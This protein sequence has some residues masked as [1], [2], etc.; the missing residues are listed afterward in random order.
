[1]LTAF[2]VAYGALQLVNGPIGDRVGKYRMIFWVTAISAAGNLA[3]AL[4]P[5]LPLLVAAR[6]AT[7]ATVGAIVPLAMAWIGDSV[8]YERRQPVLARFLIGTMLGGALAS[9]A[10]A[11]LGERY[12]WPAIFYLL[13]ALYVVAAVLLYA[14][15]RSNPATRQASAARE[16]FSAAFPRM[17]GLLR[18]RWVRVVLAT[19]FLEGALSYA[20]LA[21][22]AYHGHR[23]L[24][25]SVAA[26]G[27]LVAAAGLGGLI[28][29]AVAGRLVPRLGERGLVAWGGLLLC[30]GLPGFA[31]STHP[32]LAAL[33]LIAQ[34]MGLYMMHN[35]LQVH[36]TQ[37]APASRGAALALFAFSLFTGQSLGVWLASMLVD[38]RGTVPLFLAAGAGLALLAYAFQ[39]RL[40]RRQ[41]AK[42]G[43]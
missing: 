10:S 34:G 23:V 25:L 4:S 32:A 22:A 27:L 19:V 9:I 5:T 11:A 43:I 33:C 6:F 28:Y 41:A 8:P 35:T 20:G 13:S 12:G 17:F 7:G 26:S 30:I 37:M 24:G 21:F 14:E 16:S 18:D 38:A 40:A 36:A 3:C 1:M 29:A 31:A 2:A 42:R 39:R 15:L